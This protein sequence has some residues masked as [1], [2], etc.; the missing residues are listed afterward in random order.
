MCEALGSQDLAVLLIIEKVGIRK[1]LVHMF[2]R[3]TK[4]I[5]I[6]LHNFWSHDN[7]FA[8]ISGWCSHLH[9]CINTFLFKEIQKAQGDGEEDDVDFSVFIKYSL[10]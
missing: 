2:H 10:L 1:E 4:Y 7:N 8:D 5:S 6:V 3:T 9:L